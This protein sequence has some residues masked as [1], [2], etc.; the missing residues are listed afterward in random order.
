MEEKIILERSKSQPSHYE[1][2]FKRYAPRVRAYFRRRVGSRE[3]AEDLT[4]ETFLKAFDH[5][6]SYRYKGYPYSAYLFRIAHNLLVNHYRKPQ[7]VSLE[8]IEYDPPVRPHYMRDAEYVWKAV[9]ELTATERAVLEAKY[10][11][12]H[13][14]RDIARDLGKSENAIKLILSRARKKLRSSPYVTGR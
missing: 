3:V 12:G 7:P 5:R 6:H 11:K 1:A 13:L 9:G 14:V 10:K 8:R 2:I 4:Q